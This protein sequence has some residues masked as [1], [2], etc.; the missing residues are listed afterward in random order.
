M[1]DRLAIWLAV[2]ALAFS[3]LA[4]AYSAGH[5]AGKLEYHKL[6][7]VVEYQNQQAGETLAQLTAER[8]DLRRQADAAAERVAAARRE[9]QEQADEGKNA[10]DKGE[11][12]RAIEPARRQVGEGVELVGC[13]SLNHDV[14]SRAGRGQ[15]QFA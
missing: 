11:L 6:A 3:T 13:W 15:R 2:L 8:D 12:E 1:T 10:L 7:A 14:L 5:K 4:L 9:A